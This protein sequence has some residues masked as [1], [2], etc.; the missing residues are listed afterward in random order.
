MLVDEFHARLKSGNGRFEN[1]V[2]VKSTIEILEQSDDESD[3]KEILQ[4]SQKTQDVSDFAQVEAEKEVAAAAD[5]FGEGSE[6]ATKKKRRKSQS[7]SGIREECPLCK[8]SYSDLR[9][10]TVCK[11]LPPLPLSPPP[12]PISSPK[13]K[14]TKK[15][16]KKAT[17][18]KLIGYSERLEQARE[19]LDFS[20]FV[21]LLEE[22]VDKSTAASVEPKW[23]K[24]VQS[25]KPLLSVSEN[26][27]LNLAIPIIKAF[28]GKLECKIQSHKDGEAALA[29]IIICRLLFVFC[30]NVANLKAD[31]KEKLKAF[32][33]KVQDLA[34]GDV[35]GQHKS[36][37]RYLTTSLHDMTAAL[38]E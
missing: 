7:Q 18:K 10:H 3:E 27:D 25:L 4:K 6:S 15:R 26:I 1:P 37:S 20:N 12:A 36:L 29:A 24:K 32:V 21:V 5:D 2:S 11:G 22:L 8:K 17:K 38:D 34:A 16:A 14:P 13:I 35:V 33:Q 9:R 23:R 19:M 31:E 28:R 30:A